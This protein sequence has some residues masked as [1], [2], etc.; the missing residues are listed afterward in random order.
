MPEP[1]TREEIVSAAI[2][3]DG[4]LSRAIAA[5]EALHRAGYAIQKPPADPAPL[6]ASLRERGQNADAD[7]VEALAMELDRFRRGWGPST[8]TERTLRHAD[9][10]TAR[11][12]IERAYSAVIRLNLDN[13]TPD[14][15]AEANEGAIEAIGHCW[16]GMCWIN[17][18]LVEGVSVIPDRGATD[19]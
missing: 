12:Y 3:D 7:D 1:S 17:R 5:I 11:W 2:G 16:D 13:Y 4:K 14:D 18:R 19:A 8:P 15:V 10:C 9:L 6:I